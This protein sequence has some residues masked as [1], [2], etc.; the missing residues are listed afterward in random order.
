MADVDALYALLDAHPVGWLRDPFGHR[1][2]AHMTPKDSRGLGEVWQLA[3]DWDA[4]RW[5]EA[6]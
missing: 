3:I 1:W 4:V 6:E 5:Q 2:R